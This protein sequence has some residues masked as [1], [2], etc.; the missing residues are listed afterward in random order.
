MCINHG[1]SKIYSC[2]GPAADP[3]KAWAPH[4][5]NTGDVQRYENGDEDNFSQC[6]EFFNYVLDEGARERL[7]DNIAG[8]LCN[9]N[10]DIQARVI[11][12][13]SKVDRKYGAMI[14]SKIN[15]LDS[16]KK[17]KANV[18]QQPK[19]DVCPLNPPRKI[20]SRL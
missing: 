9:A 1:N 7:T 10:K 3:T 17:S 12:N 2:N 4:P 20:V 16:A 8:H 13:F 14:L 6:H 11:D 15:A 5:T 19:K 18:K